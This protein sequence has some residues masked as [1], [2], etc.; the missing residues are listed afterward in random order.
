MYPLR[1]LV[2]EDDPVWQLTLQMA[3]ELHHNHTIVEISRFDEAQHYLST[4]TPDVVIADVLLKKDIVFPLFESKTRSY[5]VIFITGHPESEY[6]KQSLQ[7]PNST[8]LVK[9]FHSFSLISAIERHL[10]DFSSVNQEPSQGLTVTGKYRQKIVLPYSDILFIQ[11]EGN[12]AIIYLTDS[13]YSI[14]RSL[15]KITPD[16]DSRFI[17]AHKSYIVNS[18]FINRIN[19]TENYINL[20]G[21]TIP[22]GRNYRNKILNY[23]Q[24]K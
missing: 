9:P 13:K 8:F 5:P 7:I 17:Q 16:L 11:A 3:L 1:I 18:D 21:V 12:Y 4:Y 2:L 6:L 15:Q 24:I 20:Q 23:S 10:A 14:K 19:P 22:I